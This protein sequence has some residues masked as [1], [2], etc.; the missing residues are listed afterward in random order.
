MVEADTSCTVNV[1]NMY[2]FPEICS[3]GKDDIMQ[4]E[5]YFQIFLTCELLV[6]VAAYRKRYHSEEEIGY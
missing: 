1:C 5:L 6:L 4:M 2:I 3:F